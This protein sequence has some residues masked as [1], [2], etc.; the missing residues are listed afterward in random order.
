MHHAPCSIVN[1]IKIRIIRRPEVRRNEFRSITL[2]K[3]DC[4]TCHF[5][6]FESAVHPEIRS[7]QPAFF[8]RMYD[9]QSL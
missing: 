1:R 2:K 5:R 9:T 8:L 7:W 3:L 6:P 4:L